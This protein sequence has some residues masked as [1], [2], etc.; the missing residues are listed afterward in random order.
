MA[1]VP[2]SE[3]VD[4]LNRNQIEALVSTNRIEF[5]LNNPFGQDRR[6]ILP[7]TQSSSSWD[8]IEFYYQE[9]FSVAGLDGFISWL[10]RFNQND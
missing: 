3:V 10:E 7:R 9:S 8:V 6:F 5:V 4:I 1:N 2:M